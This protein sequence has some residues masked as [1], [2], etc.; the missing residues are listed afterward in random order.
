MP[1]IAPGGYKLF[2]KGERTFVTY[3]TYFTDFLERTKCIIIKFVYE[4]RFIQM[5]FFKAPK[6]IKDELYSFTRYNEN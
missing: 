2:N 5:Y 6:Q 1:R 4:A 3:L